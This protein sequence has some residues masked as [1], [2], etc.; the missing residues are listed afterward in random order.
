MHLLLIFALQICATI[1]GDIPRDSSLTEQ[2]Q[3]VARDFFNS[4]LRRLVF[5][6]KL[7]PLRINNYTTSSSWGP[8]TVTTTFYSIAICGLSSVKRSG[9]NFF[10]ANKNGTTVTVNL[11]T[12]ELT[13]TI[14][15][16]V[17]AFVLECSM[18]IILKAKSL[19]IRLAIAEKTP[20]ELKVVS[21]EAA[22][23]S[24]QMEITRIG[25]YKS[26][27][28]TSESMLGTSINTLLTTDF[29][30]TIYQLIDHQVKRLNNYVNGHS[31]AK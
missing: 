5:Q 30:T 29:N 26:L 22:L 8:F 24:V 20:R 3:Q 7:D 27:C 12:D 28:K 17:S 15:A 18:K 9:P 13:S 10:K 21:L 16:N 1:K 6:Y 31:T 4:L 2:P 11:A 23:D 25:A 19:S 14:Y